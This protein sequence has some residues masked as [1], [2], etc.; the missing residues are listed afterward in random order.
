VVDGNWKYIHYLV[1]AVGDELYDLKS[2]PDELVNRI[3]DS[4]STN[5]LKKLRQTM[6]AELARTKAPEILSRIEN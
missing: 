1:P 6:K 4:S 3:T 5:V 2:D